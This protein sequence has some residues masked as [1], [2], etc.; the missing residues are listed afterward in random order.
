VP[1]QGGDLELS[2]DLLTLVNSA[3]AVSVATRDGNLRPAFSRA[4]GP[5]LS[6]DGRTMT[7]CVIAPLG[8][9][10]RANLEQNGAIAVGL[11]MPTTARTAQL[12][13]VAVDVREPRPD[14]LERAGHHVDA[15]CAEVEP[16]GHP[17]AVV[18]RMFRPADFLSVTFPVD[19]RFEQTPGPAAGRRL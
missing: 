4:W 12:K 9:R 8:S 16:L 3:V 13:G 6:D 17:A 15:F 7:L 19:E 1:P 18:R 11:S 14:E 2:D 5:C 10:T